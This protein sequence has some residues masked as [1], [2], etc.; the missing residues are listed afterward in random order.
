MCTAAVAYQKEESWPSS[1]IL[2]QPRM[3]AGP[4]P[5]VQKDPRAPISSSPSAGAIE[6]KSR[7]IFIR[8]F[9]PP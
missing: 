6:H 9:P 3:Q 2:F 1:K 5:P 4:T 7:P 8:G